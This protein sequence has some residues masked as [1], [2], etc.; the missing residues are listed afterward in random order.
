VRP[1]HA[2]LAAGALAALGGCCFGDPAT[3][4][5]CV[6]ASGNFPRCEPFVGAEA[7]WVDAG[8]DLRPTGDACPGTLHAG[9][10]CPAVGFTQPCGQGWWVRPGDA[11]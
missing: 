1:L 6:V 4:G 8:L 10:D 2:A 7:C 5:A 9:E 3:S 11:C